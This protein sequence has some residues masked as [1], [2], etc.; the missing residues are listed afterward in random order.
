MIVPK[1]KLTGFWYIY[2]IH[3]FFDGYT[4]VLRFFCEEA[5]FAF[6]KHKY[7]IFLGDICRFPTHISV[8]TE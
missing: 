1:C 5:L 8:Q 4:I 2:I 3:F 7:F 6:E